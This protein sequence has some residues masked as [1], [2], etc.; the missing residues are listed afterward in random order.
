MF[1]RSIPEEDA[2]SIRDGNSMHVMTPEDLTVGQN[3][4]VKD[5]DIDV[6]A[7]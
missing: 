7:S 2:I 1:L 6:C 5:S 4:E 3:A